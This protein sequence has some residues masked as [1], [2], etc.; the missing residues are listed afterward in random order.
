MSYVIQLS[1]IIINTKERKKTLIQ[2]CK[3]ELFRYIWGVIREHNCHLYRINGIEN[4]IHLL[5]GIHQSVALME[6][7]REIKRASSLWIKQSGKFPMFDG[8]SKEYAAFSVSWEAKDNVI[9]YIRNQEEHHKTTSF[10]EELKA[11][12]SQYGVKLWDSATSPT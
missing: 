4:H 2:D 8:W 12:L 1:H 6:L 7:V 10:I 3:N 9:S 11:M 5:V